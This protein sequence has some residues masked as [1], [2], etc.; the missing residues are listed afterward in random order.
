[1][2]GMA[3]EEGESNMTVVEERLSLTARSGAVLSLEGSVVNF[4]G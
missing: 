1:M 4:P 3:A 2:I